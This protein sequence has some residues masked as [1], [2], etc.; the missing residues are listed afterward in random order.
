VEIRVGCG[1]ESRSVEVV[2][3]IQEGRDVERRVGVWR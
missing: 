1:E 3:N 2:R